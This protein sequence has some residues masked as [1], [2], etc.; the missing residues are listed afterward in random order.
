MRVLWLGA[1]W[2][3]WD[4]LYRSFKSLNE[5]E[6]TLIRYDPP[7]AG[8]KRIPELVKPIITETNFDVII[9]VGVNGGDCLPTTDEL[10][11]LKK[12][13]PII[14]LCPEA[15]DSYWWYGLIRKY[16]EAECIDLIVNIDGNSNWPYSEH[17]ITRLTPIDSASWKTPKSWEERKYLCGT[18]GGRTGIRDEILSVLGDAV[19]WRGN[20][21]AR[22]EHEEED[23]IRTYDLY[24]DFNRDCRSVLNIGGVWTYANGWL[25]EGRTHVKGRVIEAGLAGATLIEQVNSETNGWFVPG[26]DYLTYTTIDEIRQQILWV[27][28]HPDDAQ[29][30]ASNLRDKVLREHSPKVFWDDIF[31]KLFT[32]RV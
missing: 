21:P 28:S 14:M 23:N 5:H 24:I 4:L 9:Y 32:E 17:G 12:F 22:P 19:I 3:G 8:G 2:L 13:A 15:S 29:K 26:E 16:Y 20:I 11:A 6:I 7:R 25:Q 27:E 31:N 30:M 10:I 1:Y 18:W